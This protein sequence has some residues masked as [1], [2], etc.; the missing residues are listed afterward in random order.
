MKKIIYF[1]N[2]ILMLEL[3]LIK[4]KQHSNTQ[5]KIMV[6]FYELIVSDN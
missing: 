6:L 1:L 5:N 4:K 2:T 3:I